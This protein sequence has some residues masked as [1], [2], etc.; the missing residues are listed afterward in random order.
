[1]TI[2]R[3]IKKTRD[4]L[5]DA[6]L[7]LLPT[8]PLNKITIKSIV[9]IANVSRSTFYVHFDDVFD[10][11]DQTVNELLA[12]LVNQ[13]TTDYPDLSEDSFSLL[14]SNLVRYIDDHKHAFVVL[15][16]SQNTDLFG[17][18]IPIFIEKILLLEHL[19]RNNPTDYYGVTYS[20]TG[21]IGVVNQW[22]QDGAQTDKQVI[23]SILTTIFEEY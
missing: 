4:A 23:I 19:D 21:T 18:M 9:D 14:V 13:I 5:S 15:T 17:R 6:L 1:M 3:R 20:V 8:T 12:G 10:L 11:Y 22:L 7:S 2:D 16:Q